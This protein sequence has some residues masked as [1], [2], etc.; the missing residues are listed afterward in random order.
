MK[1]GKLVGAG[2]RIIGLTLPFA[3]AGIAVNVVW[4]SVFRM[5]FGRAGLIAGAVLLAI[6]VP[7][8]LWA[9]AQILIYVPQGRLI[10]KGPYALVLHPIYT[11]FAFLVIPGFGLVMDTWIGFLIAGALYAS[12]RLFA[13][14]EERQVAEDFPAEYP[15]YRASVLLPWL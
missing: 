12:S 8:W 13:R 11:V 4:P 14:S 3:A 5:G 6:G 9:V 15:S 2:D 10:T 7:L 1:L